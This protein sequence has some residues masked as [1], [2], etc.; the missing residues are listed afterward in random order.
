MPEDMPE[1]MSEYMP[2]DMSDRMPE[3]I[4][5]YMPEDMPDR[6]P[7]NMPEDMPDRMPDRMPEDLPDR[8]P[9]NMPEDMPDRM[10]EDMPDRMPDRMPNGAFQQL[11]RL[12][13]RI[14]RAT[15]FVGIRS[16]CQLFNLFFIQLFHR[17]VNK[18]FCNTSG[19][20]PSIHSSTSAFLQ[21]AAWWQ[22]G[23]LFYDGGNAIESKCRVRPF[24]RILAV[25]RKKYLGENYPAQRQQHSVPIWHP[26][27]QLWVSPEPLSVSQSSH[28][29]FRWVFD[30]TPP[31]FFAQRSLFLARA[32][33]FRHTTFV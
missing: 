30:Q 19:V 15:I 8:M 21:I 10:P 13:C 6:M 14:H 1:D 28:R 22:G 24:P 7:D 32:H 20:S 27:H 5:E 2:E 3:D 17:R 12:Q 11:L 23:R 16:A 25:G 29:H 26:A 18:V 9:E 33:A 4:S 31:T